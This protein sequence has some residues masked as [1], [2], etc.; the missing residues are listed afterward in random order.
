MAFA[1]RWRQNDDDDAAAQRD[2]EPLLPLLQTDEMFNAARCMKID[3]LGN[4][5]GEQV[6]P[7]TS[8]S[9]AVS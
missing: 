4:D 8:A 7:T 3:P 6:A 1:R 9:S 2:T 5:V